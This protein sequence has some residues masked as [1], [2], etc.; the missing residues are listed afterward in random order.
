MIFEKLTSDELAELSRFIGA[1]GSRAGLLMA[2]RTVHDKFP[3][4]IRCNL[5]GLE[6]IVETRGDKLNPSQVVAE[7]ANPEESILFINAVKPLSPMKRY[8]FYR[9]LFHDNPFAERIARAVPAGHHVF[10]ILESAWLAHD[11]NLYRLIGTAKANRR[12]EF[13]YIFPRITREF[14]DMFEVA[15][16]VFRPTE[17]E[18]ATL[19]VK[20]PSPI[21]GALFAEAAGIINSQNLLV[22]CIRHWD[23]DRFRRMVASSTCSFES[24]KSALNFLFRWGMKHDERMECIQAIVGAC[25]RRGFTLSDLINDTTGDH[26]NSLMYFC[27]EGVAPRKCFEYLV[28]MGGDVK[29]VSSDGHTLADWAAR[30]GYSELATYLVVNHGVHI[31]DLNFALSADCFLSTEFLS[32]LLDT[33]GCVDLSPK[34]ITLDDGTTDFFQDGLYQVALSGRTDLVQL[35]IDRGVDLTARIIARPESDHK[36]TILH[37]VIELAQNRYITRK[38]NYIEQDTYSTDA[39]RECFVEVA[40]LC[41]EHAPEV[42]DIRG[43]DNKLPIELVTGTDSIADQ[44]RKTITPV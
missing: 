10:A 33:P 42:V 24:L 20:S 35:L 7:F 39:E 30:R 12:I 16:E 22:L 3:N 8:V 26:E 28:S 43:R 41:L 37:C 32:L 19:A 2:N 5:E 23:Y 25:G 29:V 27:R 31:T 4:V 11:Q 15:I 34:L 13:K 18:I 36:I 38:G 9:S 40:R 21:G 17:E 14:A 44:L 1:D 6:Y